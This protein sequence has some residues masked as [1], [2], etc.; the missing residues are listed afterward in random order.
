MTPEE[1]RQFEEMKLQIEEIH[2]LIPAFDQSNILDGYKGVTDADIDLT[3]SVSGGAGGSVVVPDFPDDLIL[4]R[5][6][7]KIG[8]IPFYFETRF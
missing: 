5:Y 7:G 3:V 2:R 4:I 1:Q 8:R 6:N